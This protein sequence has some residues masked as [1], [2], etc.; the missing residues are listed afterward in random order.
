V[1]GGNLTLSHIHGY[2]LRTDT[3]IRR[4]LANQ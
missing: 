1:L 3:L 2:V 4:T